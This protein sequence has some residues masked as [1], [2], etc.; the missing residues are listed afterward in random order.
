MWKTFPEVSPN[1]V[2]KFAGG[3]NLSGNGGSDPMSKSPDPN[4]TL[5]RVL[6]WI[7][8]LTGMVAIVPLMLIAF[9]EPGSGPREVGEWVY[10]ALFPFGFSLGYL[11]GWRWPL[12]AGI[13]S[14]GCLATS[15]VVIGRVFPPGAYLIWGVL[16]LPGVLYVLAGW[17]LREEAAS[18]CSLLHV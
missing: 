10:L 1:P 2:K 13:L 8:R 3:T 4:R 17:K 11:L 16:S 14:L 6:L 5:W 9:G 15:L 7:A 12:V 18:R